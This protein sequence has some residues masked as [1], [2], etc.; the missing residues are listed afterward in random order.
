M[1]KALGV[2]ERLNLE[3]L[4]AQQ[5]Y[6]SLQAREA[7]Y[8]LIPVAI[9]QRMGVLV[10]SPIAGGLLSGKYRRGVEPPRGSRHLTEWNEP[11]VRDHEALYDVVETLVEIAESRGATPA[12]VALAWLLRR[13]GVT[14]LVIGART[15][16]QLEDNLV[17]ADLRLS[18]EEQSALDKVSAPPL[19]YPFWH[20]AK[21]ASDRLSEADLALLRPYVTG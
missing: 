12:Q 7:E 18:D 6:Y 16:E 4:V 1:M 8:E 11:P 21:T 10:W 17:A 20:Q 15:A 9:D 19:V 13:P 14:S 3:P 5:T 2:S